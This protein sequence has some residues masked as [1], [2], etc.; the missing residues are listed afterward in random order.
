MKIRLLYILIL[1]FGLSVLSS[2]SRDEDDDHPFTRLELKHYEQFHSNKRELVFFLETFEEFPCNNFQINTQVTHSQN[3]VEI[4]AENIEVPSFCMTSFGPATRSIFL[5]DTE[6]SPENY[7]VWVNF[8][9][10]DFELLINETSIEIKK[11]KSFD[12]RLSFSREKLMRIPDNTV[13]GYLVS[14]SENKNNITESLLEIF[15]E[16]G[17]ELLPLQDGD[18]HYFHVEDET[19]MFFDGIGEIE[20]FSFLFDKEIQVLISAFQNYIDQSE[21]DN[22][23]IRLFSTR[24]ERFLL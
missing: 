19:V 8:D 21:I 5:G 23:Q 15:E 22:V 2:C 20:G 11:G 12:T 17:A 18:Y 4:H 14:E 13:W 16:S 24:G 9:R 3:Q 1:A 6:K 7:S 10:H